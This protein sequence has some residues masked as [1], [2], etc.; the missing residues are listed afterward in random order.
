MILLQQMSGHPYLYQTFYEWNYLESKSKYFK[1]ELHY[2][3][4]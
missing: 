4:L 3:I 2:V 1:N